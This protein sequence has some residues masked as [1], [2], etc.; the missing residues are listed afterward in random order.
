LLTFSLGCCF[1]AMDAQAQDRAHR[2]GQTREVHIYRLVCKSTVE[3]NILTKA[4]QKRHLDFLVMSEGDF[5]EGSL[6]NSKNLAGLLGGDG[7]AASDKSS[8]GIEARMAAEV[9]AD[10]I[11]VEAAMAAVEDDDDVSAMKGARAEAAQE[12]AEFDENAVIPVGDEDA[13]AGALGE[14][15]QAVVVV[16][17]TKDDDGEADFASWQESVGAKDFRTIEAALR[18]VERYALSFRTH[19]DPF[20]SFHYLSEQQRLIEMQADE[21][22]QEWDIETIEKEKEEEEFRALSEGEL[23]AVNLTRRELS[24][25]KSDYLK[26]KAARRQARLR[27]QITGEAW[28]HYIDELTGAPFWYN[29]DTGEASYGK[30]AIIQKRDLLAAA[31]ERKYNACPLEILLRVFAFLPAY[32]DRIRC[33]YICARW[34]KAAIDP[35]FHKCVLPIE[36]GVKDSGPSVDLG[37][38]TFASLTAALANAQRGDTIS[39]GNGHHWEA[40]LTIDIPVRIIGSDDEP[41]RVVVEVAEGISISPAARRVALVG[42]CF[43]RSRRNAVPKTLLTVEGA[44]VNV[45]AAHYYYF[46]LIFPSCSCRFRHAYSATTILLEAACSQPWEHKCMP[47]TV[48]S[49]EV[50]RPALPCLTLI[51]VSSIAR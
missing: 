45:S 13:A 24:R 50:P 38:N 17:K 48:I 21:A 15:S 34:Y 5:N 3:E 18:P 26:E 47:L 51:Y 10:V 22:G 8:G 19:V 12:A 31:K 14:G 1:Q 42:V 16:E 40:R 28:M 27:R 32:P 49:R 23:L 4:R 20:F 39:L 43:M 30:P 25:I 9:G 35:S 41:S 44:S 2:I 46:M 33:S 6:F 11:D 36:T 29:E 37:E 7:A